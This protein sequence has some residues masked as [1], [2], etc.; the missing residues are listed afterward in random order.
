M[1][2]NNPVNQESLDKEK[3]EQLKKEMEN[4]GN[5]SIQE[6][7]PQPSQPVQQPEAFDPPPPVVPEAANSQGLQKSKGILWIALFLLLLAVVGVGAYYLGSN[8]STTKPDP[9]AS[10]IQT[11]VSKPDPTEDWNSYIDSTGY[12]TL[13]YP[14]N[15]GVGLN[16]PLIGKDYKLFI[17]T[18]NITR[19]ED[20]P[21]NFTK[22][23]ALNDSESLKKG[24]YGERVGFSLPESEKV[25]EIDGTNAKIYMS[26]WNGGD[27]CDVQIRRTMII[28]HNYQRTIVSLSVETDS[29]KAIIEE[30]PEYFL[31]DR[32]VCQGYDSWGYE[33]DGYL[34]F[35]Q[36]LAEKN[37]SSKTAT[38]WYDVFDQIISTFKFVE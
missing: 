6:T 11:P 37:N 23:N 18:E 9:T 12:F 20:G 25:I 16:K 31:I 26:S 3:I 29:I 10:P 22:E 13:K 24:E 33:N 21:L 28:Y 14:A 5:K 36:D 7:S 2:E 27:A 17:G 38:D 15:V 35:Y 1:D 19:I 4:I 32:P 8:K 34:N 30:A